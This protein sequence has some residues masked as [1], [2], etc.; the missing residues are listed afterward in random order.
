MAA[1]NM[2]SRRSLDSKPRSHPSAR[3]DWFVPRSRPKVALLIETSN[4]Y[5]RGLLQ[6]VVTYI[7]E[8]EPWSFY[9]MEQ[10]RGDDP[11]SWLTHWDGDGVI[12]R[13]ESKSI[14]K[15]IM[16]SKLPTVDLSAGR[17]IPT[18]PWVETDDREIAQLAA[19]HFLERGFKHFA[20]CGDDRFNWSRWRGDHF[21]T[22]LK[23]AGHQCHTFVSP[24]RQ[25]DTQIRA[26]EDWLRQLPKPVGVFACYDIRGQQVLDACRN[27]GLAVPDEIAVLGVDNDELLCELS[28]PHLSSVVPDTHRAGYEAAALLARMMKGECLAVVEVRIAP[29]GV[30]RRQSTDVLATDDPH[31]VRAVRFIRD[32]A[33]EPIKVK[34]LLRAVPLSRKVLETRFKKLLNHTLHDEIVRVRVD[35]VKQLLVNTDLT[36]ADIASRTGFEHSEYLSVIFKRETGF[37]PAVYRVDQGN[38]LNAQR[39][40]RYPRAN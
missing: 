4:A 14:A 30:H 18:I 33:C 2:K 15:V 38:R 11:P 34:D 13:I 25:S 29:I 39:K 24:H 35:R 19:N 23:Y 21:G 17:H 31:V 5:A 26:I 3:A 20:Y 10:G 8:H 9:L 37:T 7:R 12:A 22:L 27:A 40:A 36:L 1:G 16:N 32:H 6:G 28:S